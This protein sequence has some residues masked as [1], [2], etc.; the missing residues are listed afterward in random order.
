MPEPIFPITYSILAP[1]ALLD[2]GY[3]VGEITSRFLCQ[4]RASY[5][6]QLTNSKAARRA[7]FNFAKE[8][9]DYR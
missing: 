3:G 4:R 9:Q 8:W 7:T 5:S 2:R 6:N 1:Q